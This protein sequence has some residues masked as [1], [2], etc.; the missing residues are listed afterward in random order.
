[1]RAAVAVALLVCAGLA[2]GVP[3][4]QGAFYQ[5]EAKDGRIYVFNNMAVY[6]EWKK[7]GE[8]GK[9]ITRVGAGP[10]GE[11]LV[12]DSEEA[13][14][15]YNFR[16]GLPGEVMIHPPEKKPVS[17]WS[18]K[19]G[20][21]TWESDKASI[22]LA[23]RIQFRYT[24]DQPDGDD[25][26]GS[27]RIRRAK[28]KFDGW[29]YTKDLTFELQMNWADMVDFTGRNQRFLEDAALSY[30]LTHGSRVVM[31]KGGQFKVPFARQEMTSS[32][33]QQF[34][35]RSIVSG[36]FSPIPRDQGIQLW[37]YTPAA[38]FEYRFGM[39][40][41]NGINRAL[42]DNDKFRFNARVA[43]MPFGEVRYSESDFETT[44][45]PL[46]GIAAVYEAN[47]F[48]TGDPNSIASDFETFGGDV[49]FKYKGI[50][51]V[52]DYYRRL[53]RPEAVGEVDTEARGWDVQGGVFVYKRFVEV[54]ARY[55][56]IDPTDVP[57]AGDPLANDHQVERGVALNWFLNKHNLKIQTD[58]RQLESELTDS[59]LDEY[60]IQT[61]WIF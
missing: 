17:S 41:G 59:T 28:T 33:S 40:N 21:T 20:R 22:N 52:A 23:N 58:Y 8:I 39:F 15:L 29:I 34:V 19:D 30:A 56:V 54:A 11:T 31:I 35:D 55:A 51:I 50:S 53:N 32:G 2:V 12:F 3:L 25:S 60:R 5:E 16:H 14:H 44:D 38:R 10:N 61:Q 47:N 37:G 46:L 27:F 1:M 9:S 13:I 45:R 4:A 18:W 48:Q 57:A 42:N 43:W 36:F 49:T 24:H 7:S 6:E 26:I